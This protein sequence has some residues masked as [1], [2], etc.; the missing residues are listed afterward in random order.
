VVLS[1]VVHGELVGLDKVLVLV[2]GVLDDLEDDLLLE[3]TLLVDFDEVVQGV[4]AG[5]V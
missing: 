4:V 5:L 2:H 1:L 3:Q